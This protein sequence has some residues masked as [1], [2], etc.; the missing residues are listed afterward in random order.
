MGLLF[1]DNTKDG[2]GL[3]LGS[4]LDPLEIQRGIK[5]EEHVQVYEDFL[6]TT[7]DGTY[8]YM[9]EFKQGQRFTA[10]KAA[11]MDG[12]SA[13]AAARVRARMNAGE[14]P[15][16][17]AIDPDTGVKIF[18]EEDQEAFEMGYICPNCIQYQAVPNAPK[19]NWLTKS[20]D[21]CGH[22]N[23]IITNI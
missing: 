3:T 18:Y 17:M 16:L 8:G 12:K 5:L 7:G 10:P 19:C 4:E 11:L 21:G 9:G 23:D 15:R 22:S 13:E 2:H 1:F 20:N 6:K 14:P